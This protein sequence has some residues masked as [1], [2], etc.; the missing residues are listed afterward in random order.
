MSNI[1]K[2][3]INKISQPTLLCWCVIVIPFLFG[4]LIN[5]L[6]VSNSVKYILDVIW[7]FLLAFIFLNVIRKKAVVIKESRV[8]Y[9]WIIMFLSFTLVVYILNY[10]SFLYYLWGFRN[11]FRFYVV[12]FA[13]IIFLKAND[14]IAFWKFVD[15]VFW[16]NAAVCF[17]QCFWFNI[18]QDYLGGIFG[19]SVGCN[20]YLNIFFVIIATKSVIFY[21]NNKES[22]WLCF[23]KISTMLFICAYAELKFFYVEFIFIIILAV[24]ITDFSWRKL[25]IAIVSLIGVFMATQ[26]LAELF[27]Q[28]SEIFTIKAMFETAYEGGY[29]S[30]VSVNRLNNIPIIS[31]RF[32]TTSSEKI[33]GLGLGNCDTADYSI[34][35]TPFYMQYSYLRYNWFSTSFIFLEMGGIGLLFF[36]GFFFVVCA[37]T[38]SMLKKDIENRVYYQITIILSI[39]CVLIGVYNASLRI[40]CGYMVYFV[41]A[42][43]FIIQ[44]E[45]MKAARMRM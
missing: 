8:L 32:L 4:I 9:A 13:F 14:V 36:F 23:I 45:S 17:L 20:G 5:L 24:I 34:V 33:F 10:Q 40:E 41:L 11:N 18:T 31:E 6:Q 22:L 29:S 26:L 44:K 16:I 28:F 3:K 38:F 12:F 35:N 30:E 37:L 42:I 19:T 21:L 27:P 15:F 25:F 1:L 7:F 2:I 39:C 43:P